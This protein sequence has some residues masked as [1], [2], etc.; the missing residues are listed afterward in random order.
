LCLQQ[1]KQAQTLRESEFY[2]P[3]VKA[4]Q[5]ELAKILSAHRGGQATAL[6]TYPVLQGM[7]HGF[8]DLV[9]EHEGRYYLADYKSNHLGYCFDDY[10]QAAMLA[11]NQA[12]YYDLQYLIYSLA[13]H[14]YLTQRIA[15]Y[16][17][18]THFG[19]VYYL[20]LRG[21]TKAATTGVFTTLVT[22]QE[23]KALDELFAGVG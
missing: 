9:F 7:M 14:R 10:N 17:P 22:P 15:D 20:Y 21:M 23:L 16:D 2:F 19:G 3:L 6:P 1:L 5:S 12:H 13:L 8:I 18:T 11:A 4:K